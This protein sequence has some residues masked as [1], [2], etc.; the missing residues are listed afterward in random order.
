MI[1]CIS[2]KNNESLSGSPSDENEP[3]I[4]NARAY[5]IRVSLALLDLG[6]FSTTADILYG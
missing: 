6:L 4:S 1:R 5:G 2:T 3:T